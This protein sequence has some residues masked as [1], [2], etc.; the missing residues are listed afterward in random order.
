[1]D[2]TPAPA[3]SFWFLMM[4]VSI[5]MN[6]SNCRRL[7]MLLKGLRQYVFPST[8]ATSERDYS[9][10]HHRRLRQKC[11]HKL[12]QLIL[13]WQLITCTSA[14]IISDRISSE[15]LQMD[16]IVFLTW[17]HSKFLHLKATWVLKV[18]WIC[19]FFHRH[20]SQINQTM[21]RFRLRCK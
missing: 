13:T 6:S 5:T 11:E 15:S 12:Y 2:L 17:T 1:M 9:E 8:S 7:Q 3:P 4:S 16:L 19:M 10:L 21:K 18:T 20:I 14:T